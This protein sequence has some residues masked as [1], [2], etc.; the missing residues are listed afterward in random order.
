VLN[1]TKF[2]AIESQYQELRRYQLEV[3]DLQNELLSIKRAK[4]EQYI[5]DLIRK[6]T[7]LRKLSESWQKKLNG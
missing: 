5:I 7:E 2:P 4:Q 3:F 1:Y 6:Y